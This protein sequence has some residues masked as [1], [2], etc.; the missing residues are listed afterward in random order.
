MLSLRVKAAPTPSFYPLSLIT[1]SFVPVFEPSIQSS[2]FAPFTVAPCL[3]L[4]SDS[5]LYYDY[6]WYYER[7]NLSSWL[8]RDFIYWLS[9]LT[10]RGDSTAFKYW[11]P[12]RI[13]FTL[14]PKQFISTHFALELSLSF[15]DAGADVFLNLQTLIKSINPFCHPHFRVK[16]QATV[17]KSPIVVS[18]PLP[19]HASLRYPPNIR[20]HPNK[21]TSYTSMMLVFLFELELIS[22]V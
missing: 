14:P 15:S 22:H 9:P 21:N 11:D 6:D 3:R 2:S 18:P 1:S 8:S 7:V 17:S 5:W 12:N 4:S 19:F 20:P 16:D 10:T 13:P